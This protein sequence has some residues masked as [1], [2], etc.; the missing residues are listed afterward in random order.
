MKLIA[1]SLLAITCLATP[2]QSTFINTLMPQPQHITVANGRLLLTDS[3]RIETGASHNPILQRATERLLQRLEAKT[4]LQLTSG[5][6]TNALHI[7]VD[8]ST[9]TRPVFGQDESY[10]LKVEANGIQ[11]HA[12]TIFGAMYGMETLFQLLQGSGKD[13]FFP[14]ATI[15]DAPRFP[16]RGLMIDPGR[17]FLSVDTVLRTIDGMAATKLNVLHWHL[18]E[19]QGFRIE[20]KRFPKL[21]QLGSNGQYYTQE[22]IKQ[23]IAYATDRGIRVLPEFDMPGHTTTWMV[24]YPE[25]G[26]RK[27]GATYTIADSNGV[28]DPVFDPTK[29]STYKFLDAYFAEMTAL[30]PDEYM[31]IGG[32][33]NNG[34]DWGA[35]ADIQAYMK[36]HNIPTTAA[37]QTA[38]NHRLQT[39]VTK[40]HKKMVGWDEILQPDLPPDVIIQNWHG[41]EFLINAAK[42]GHQGFLSQPFY[43]DHMR[44]AEEVYS[45]DPIPA[46]SNLTPA[47]AKLVLGGE[48]CMWGEQ[49]DDL[50]IDSRIW[51]RGAV[52]AERFWSPATTRDVA[53]MYRRLGPM[54]LRLDALGLQNISGP[55]RGL[56]QL[57]GPNPVEQQALATFDSVLQPVDFHERYAEQHTGPSTP[58]GRLVDFTVP[59]PPMRYEFAAAVNEYLHSADKSRRMIRANQLSH[60]FLRW[61]E[62]SMAV[63]RLAQNSPLIAEEVERRRQFRAIAEMGLSAV[64]TMQ[65]NKPAEA[66]WLSAQKQVL[67]DAAK[68]TELVD[69]VILKPLNDLVEATQ[70]P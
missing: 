16:W 62:A 45:Y 27:P 34:K 9:A 35:N 43:L 42:Q 4:A 13:F 54:Q 44:S 65:A 69:F 10:S 66:D 53:D 7:T 32:D 21:H 68:H 67:T 63:D 20:S 26:S 46:G 15:D 37:L 29:E 33:E 48:I 24:A 5:A 52:I 64:L 51:P 12:K 70:A 31:H 3:F 47:Q 8:D 36:A 56:R 14:T 40:Y 23:V 58:F 18:T 60:T 38:F 41:P 1:A 39:I 57:A 59:D 11:L 25:L 6:G 19:D 28:K 50:A 55:Q 49:V 2:A 30:F 22:Q 17:H 61:R